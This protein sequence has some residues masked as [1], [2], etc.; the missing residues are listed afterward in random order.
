MFNVSVFSPVIRLAAQKDLP[1]I[2]D[3][4]SA[5]VL[6]RN[7]LWVGGDEGT[8][9]HRFSGGGE[10]GYGNHRSFD[11]APLFQLT[12]AKS[13]IDVEGM[14]VSDGY[15][16][17]VGSHSLKRKKPKRDDPNR[18]NIERMAKLEL[19]RNRFTLGRVPL[20]PEGDD[21]APRA[22]FKSKF[23][24][25]LT[26]DAKGNAL[27]EA[28]LNDPHLGRYV[29]F[30]SD[31]K[32]RG[33]PSKDNG[34]DIEGM[35]VN[36][37]RVFVGLRGP[38]LRGWAVILEIL[39]AEGGSGELILAPVS[40]DGA[41]YRKHFLQLEGLG[42]R[43]LV[44]QGDDLFILAGPSMDLDGPVYVFQWQKALRQKD[45]ALVWRD[46]LSIV[47]SVPYGV[48]E[49]CGKDHAEGMTAHSGDGAD[50]FLICYDSPAKA[51]LDGEDG[52]RGDVFDRDP[53]G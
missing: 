17:L 15:L 51:R 33:I 5:V 42:V 32:P 25:R 26:G 28:L 6:H 23:A 29:P 52:V 19:E 43:D 22:S 44:I 11:L 3:N 34:F 38:V 14:D 10:S 27:T 53:R 13:E 41:L 30:Q 40:S 21:L 45:E 37:G 24:A 48:G 8:A 1:A 7:N 9:V 16:W 2:R 39:I 47:L 50:Q 35:A 49:D 4:M 31:G 20:G 46:Q 36:G 18:D 12:D